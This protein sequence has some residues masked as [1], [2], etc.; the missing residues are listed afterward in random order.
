MRVTASRPRAVQDGKH[1][2]TEFAIRARIHANHRS[3][4]TVSELDDIA[5][6]NPIEPRELMR[7]RHQ[8]LRGITTASNGHLLGPENRTGS[9]L[10]APVSIEIP[11]YPAANRF[12]L[13]PSVDI[14]RLTEA[15]I[16]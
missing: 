1:N 14:A 8:V 9:A 11:S 5:H 16:W 6:S 4:A 13:V 7:S 12:G 15:K 10:E 2:A 3:E